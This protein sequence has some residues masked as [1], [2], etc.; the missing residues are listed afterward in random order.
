MGVVAFCA[1]AWARHASVSGAHLRFRDLL[2]CRLY[3]QIRPDGYGDWA[4]VIAGFQPAQAWHI[5]LTVAGIVLYAAAIRALG[6]LI[7]TR[8]GDGEG[9]RPFSL[10]AIAYVTA[11]LL[12]VAGAALDPRG[13]GT[14]FNDA[15]PSS[16]GAVGLIWAGFV[17]QRRALDFRIAVPFSP[18]WLIVGLVSAVLYVA[19]LGPG[20]RFA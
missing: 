20:L 9:E 10:T 15:L 3:D 16:L 18:A 5:G 19:V 1:A 2:E 8:L 6:W 11:V 17:V 4:F 12:S 13:A 7:F 14:I